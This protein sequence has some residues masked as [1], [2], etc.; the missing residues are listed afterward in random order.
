VAE[1]NSLRI[2]IIEIRA[3]TGD[4]ELA[5]PLGLDVIGIVGQKLH[6]QMD[7]CCPHP[8]CGCGFVRS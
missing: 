1:I 6:Q 2:K 8:N 4:Y 7:S 3:Y 5:S